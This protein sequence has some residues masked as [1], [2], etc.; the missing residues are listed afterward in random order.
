MARQRKTGDGGTPRKRVR[1]YA[2]ENARREARARELGFASAYERRTR[3]APGAERPSSELLRRL[4]GH[5]S[6]RD[7]AGHVRAGSLVQVTRTDRDKA[8]RLKRV[9]VL[10]VEPDGSELTFDIR[11]ARALS[12]RNLDR[13]AGAIEDA[14]ALVSPLYPLK[15]LGE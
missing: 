8:G 3:R 5:A 1:D 12:Q 10:V 2:A 7:L 15:G 11:G 9:E 13:L 4:R 6:A 14:G